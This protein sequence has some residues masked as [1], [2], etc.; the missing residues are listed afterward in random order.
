[1]NMKLEPKLRRELSPKTLVVS[2]DFPI[3][4]W[5]SINIVELTHRSWQRRLYVYLKGESEPRF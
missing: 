5:R 1:M 3:P 4:G 2:L